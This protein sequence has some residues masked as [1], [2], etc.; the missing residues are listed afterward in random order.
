[1]YECWGDQKKIQVVVMLEVYW[2]ALS[3]NSQVQNGEIA[4]RFLMLL[5]LGWLI[6]YV[7]E[8]CQNALIKWFSKFGFWTLT[9]SIS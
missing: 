2:Q 1:M 5:L 9:C 7:K 4:I 6:A 3:G 8:K